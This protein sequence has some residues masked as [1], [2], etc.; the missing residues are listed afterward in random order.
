[1]TEDRIAI[2]T[3]AGKGI[4]AACARGLAE[5]G[6][7]VV[8]M[9]VSGSAIALAAELGGVGMRGSIVEAADLTALVALA[10]GRYG[11][12]DVVVCNT[13]HGAGTTDYNHASGFHADD[14]VDR[15][16]LEIDDTAWHAGLDLYLMVTVRMARLVTPI[17]EA[18]GGGVLLNISSFAATEARPASPMS[19]LRGALHGFAKLY[20]D[21]YAR[22]GIR[23]NNLLP[24]FMMNVEIGEQAA[25]GIPLGRSATERELAR[26]VAFLCGPDS[27]YITGQNI[28]MDG[29]AN[30][31]IPH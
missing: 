19:I 27:G 17:M 29:G 9:S 22:A 6:H 12:I 21:R 4:G 28:L 15:L 18:Q 5:T 30:R 1:M 14:P 2:V 24:G 25:N 23:M 16:L 20:S 7:K 13:G 26:T 3:A 10:M 8:L 11:R 31:A